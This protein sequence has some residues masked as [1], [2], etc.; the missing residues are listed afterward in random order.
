MYQMNDERSMFRYI[1]FGIFTLGIYNLWMIHFLA[2][3]ANLLCEGTGRK[4]TGLLTFVLLSILSF[5][6]YGIFWWF[7]IADMLDRAARARKLRS[8]VNAPTVMLAMILSYFL[9]PIAGLIGVYQVLSAANDL[10]TEYN[11]EQR[12]RLYYDLPG[13]QQQ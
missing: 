13:T 2:K 6:L 5:G 1:V 8:T 7:R 9:T 3:D 4:T 10:A 11:R 12:R